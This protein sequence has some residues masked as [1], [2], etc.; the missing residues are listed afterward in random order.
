M[1]SV[2]HILPCRLQRAGFTLTEDEDF[3]IIWHEGEWVARFLGIATNL[4]NILME[5]DAHL[6]THPVVVDME[7]AGV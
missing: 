2:T 6:M 4:P 7:V 1:W 3:L 5:C